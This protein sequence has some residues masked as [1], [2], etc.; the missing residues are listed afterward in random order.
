MSCDGAAGQLQ[1]Q[2]IAVVIEIPV[3]LELHGAIGL[4][5]L[6]GGS[7]L[8]EQCQGESESET[9]RYNSFHKCTPLRLTRAQQGWSSRRLQQLCLVPGD[10]EPVQGL[11]SEP[12][13]PWRQTLVM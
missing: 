3:E 4:N 7:L 2:G 11:G 8:G 6:G 12:D 5:D 1:D 13:G 10:G 9:H